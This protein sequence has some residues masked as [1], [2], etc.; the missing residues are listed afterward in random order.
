MSEDAHKKGKE[1]KDRWDKWKIVL[2]PLGGLLTAVA[3]VF[4]TYYTSKQLESWH[5]VEDNARAKEDTARARWQ[6]NENNVRVYTELMGKREE[7]ETG[8]RKAMFDSIMTAFLKSSAGSN[9]EDLKMSPES[10]DPDRALQ[11]DVLKI[12]LLAYNFN[13]SLN[14]TPLFKNLEREIEKK[15]KDDHALQAEAKLLTDAK[16]QTIARNHADDKEMTDTTCLKRL[17][18][19]ANDI[20]EK[21]LAALKEAD[22]RNWDTVL[23]GDFDDKSKIGSANEPFTFT[24]DEITHQ[25]KV[26]ITDID[27]V[28][29]EL[30]VSLKVRTSSNRHG[31]K[32]DELLETHAEFWIGSFEFPMIDNTRLPNDQRCALVLRVIEP[33]S[34]NKAYSY[35]VYGVCFPGSR[36]ALKEKPYYDEILDHLRQANSTN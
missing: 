13:E 7:A 4:L 36:A 2:E 8:L 27:P 17:R 6:E 26:D 25:V 31:T 33:D 18:K 21:Q 16:R 28:T 19:V 5:I 30:L 3:V 20:T 24:V 9:Q 11:A 1:S 32:T 10:A 15:L 23:R 35:L 14:L 29:Q 22:G 34:E 12:E